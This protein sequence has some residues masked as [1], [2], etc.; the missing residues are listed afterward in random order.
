MRSQESMV[1]VEATLH[2]GRTP[3]G[4]LWMEEQHH[5]WRMDE[6]YLEDEVHSMF[7][8]SAI[9]L[10]R[11]GY[12]H[13]NTMELSRRLGMEAVKCNMFFLHIPL[14]WWPQPRDILLPL[15]HVS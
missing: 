14:V 3:A 6:R 12:G 1:E 13:A 15:L 4:F 9:A 5:K 11:E 10:P 8:T 7:G 2:T